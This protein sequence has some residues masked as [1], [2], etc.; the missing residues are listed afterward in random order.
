MRAREELECRFAGWSED[1]EG[2]EER[3]YGDSGDC[4][5]GVGDG[6][7]DCNEDFRI[8]DRLAE[9]EILSPSSIGSLYVYPS[10]SEDLR[11]TEVRG[12]ILLAKRALALGG[13]VGDG[14]RMVK[15]ALSS[16][17]N[18]V[19]CRGMF[20]AEDM[21][22]TCGWSCVLVTRNGSALGL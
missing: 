8:R 9:S 19:I 22:W 7:E 13:I 17:G 1:C 16:I 5:D 11:I 21:R 3:K 6:D 12:A 10:G 18:S 15:A 2:L 14:L 4:G 20:G